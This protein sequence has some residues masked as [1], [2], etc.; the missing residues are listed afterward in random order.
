MKRILVLGSV[1]LAALG[2]GIRGAPHPPA[3]PAPPPELPPGATTG[4]VTQPIQRGPFNPSAAPDAGA[5]PP[6]GAADAGSPDAGTS[7]QP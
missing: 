6:E 5:A 1:G 7:G 4:P 3:Q 2:C